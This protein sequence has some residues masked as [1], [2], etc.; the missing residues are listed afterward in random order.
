MFVVL[1]LLNWLAG[2]I[3][4]VCDFVGDVVAY[5][6]NP[7]HRRKA[8]ERLLQIIRDVARQSPRAQILVV[9]H[10]LGSVLV[11]HTA[12]RLD[13]G[14]DLH[15]RLRIITMGSPLRMMSWFFPDRIHSAAQLRD[16]YRHRRLVSS[17]ANMWR[18]ADWIGRSLG[19]SSV[20]E[21]TARGYAETSLGDGTHA[22][23]WADPRCWETVVAYLQSSA[24]G[25]MDDLT[26]M[27]GRGDTTEDEERELIARAQLAAKY[28]VT[29]NLV[30]AGGMIYFWHWCREQ[31]WLSTL[32][33]S[34]RLPVLAL[35][36]IVSL[37][38]A[39]YYFFTSR[40]VGG[41]GITRREMLAR[42]RFNWSIAIT[43]LKFASLF[44]AVLA[45]V[46][47]SSWWA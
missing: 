23:Y 14:E 10:S 30:F 29:F 5:V 46:L 2:K 13:D 33:D 11:T 31:Q 8:E 22:D 40:R 35:A 28:A 24:D 7:S 45:F 25:S 27:W 42:Y 18:D 43:C 26:A 47:W 9:G 20:A 34:V 44:T 36:G 37:L 21:S 6:G 19:E 16:E 41:P 15:H 3:L 17:W 39:I 32:S 38:V 4:M 1:A 12:L